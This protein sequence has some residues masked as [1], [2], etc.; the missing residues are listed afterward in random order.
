MMQPLPANWPNRDTSRQI[1]CKPHL[2][3]VQETGSGPVLLLIH[4]AGG[5]T[6]SFRGLI[7]LLAHN[8]RVIAI[9]IPGQGFSRAGPGTRSDL[10]SFA[11]DILALIRQENWQPLVIIGHSAGGALALRLAEMMPLRAVIGIN[12]ALGRFEGVAGWLFPALANVLT[13]LPLVPQLFSKLAGTPAQVHQLLTSTG[14]RIGAEGEGQYLYL[15][16]Q[17]GHVSATLSM[18]AQWKLDDMLRRLPN[19]TVPCLLITAAADRA[20]P[21]AVSQR[22]AHKMPN[23]RWIDLPGFG[24]LVH[25][26][27]AG[28]VAAHITDFLA[29]LPPAAPE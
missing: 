24:H 22:A 13:R 25:E 21:P 19:Q 20:V 6:H 29:T 8:H 12:A 11:R 1:A 16:R 9:D 27:A 10:D 17:P 2:W 14:S 26:E 23:A 7:P 3:H 18:M 5:A 15:L 4:G 28:E